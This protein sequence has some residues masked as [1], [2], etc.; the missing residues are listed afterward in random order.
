[1]ENWDEYY[2][3]KYK[4]RPLKKW[5][6]VRKLKKEARN[7]EQ[8][9][10][11]IKAQFDWG[12]CE[13]CKDRI[14]LHNSQD[15]L[16]ELFNLMFLKNMCEINNISNLVGFVTFAGMDLYTMYIHLIKAED[17][18]EKKFFS[19]LVCMNMYELTGDILQLL[20]NDKDK[21]T[22]RLIGIRQTVQDIDDEA[23]TKELNVLSSKW[24]LFWNETI[25]RGT[26][27]DVRNITVAHKDHIFS[28][29]YESLKAISWGQVMKDFEEFR[30]IYNET[31]NF[32]GCFMLKNQ[33]K[34]RHDMDNL[35]EKM[36]EK[37]AT[38]RGQ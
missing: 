32:I 22:G 4:Y 30:I 36:K 24:N 29:Q 12:L 1:M 20:G 6:Y 35:I 7:M 38:L 17:D 13:E 37:I 10:V 19:R 16:D 5:L 26:Y 15:N 18:R 27:Q 21:E 25:K 31:N 33:K 3:N 14:S 34:F 23:L 8:H 9:L 2:K 11:F 28:K